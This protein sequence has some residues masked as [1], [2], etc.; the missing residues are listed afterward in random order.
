MNVWPASTTSNQN[1]RSMAADTGRLADRSGNDV[2]ATRNAPPL[3]QLGV[4][5]EETAL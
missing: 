4:H 5:G 1:G 2:P 3:K